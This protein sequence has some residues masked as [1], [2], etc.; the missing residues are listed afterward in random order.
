MRVVVQRAKNASVRVNNETVGAIDKGLVLLVGFTL[1]D[2]ESKLDWM[3]N[4]VTNL[5]IYE[6][7]EGKMNLSVKDIGGEILSIS[8]FTLYGNVKKGFR[9]SFTKALNPEDAT[10]LFDLFNQKLNEVVHTE[11]GQFGEMMEVDFVND[12]P[13]TIIVEK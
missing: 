7:E 12:G 4:K 9:P 5:R 10:R 3:I 11:T 2:D 13:V 8:Q 1:D 6:D